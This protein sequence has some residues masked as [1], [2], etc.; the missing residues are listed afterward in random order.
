MA[1]D[2]SSI[3]TLT[4]SGGD[5]DPAWSPDGTKIA[6]A[7][8]GARALNHGD[9]FVVNSDGSGR[10]NLTNDPA[11]DDLPA[12][13]P[14]GTKIAFVSTRGGAHSIFVMNA[15]GT[16]VTRLTNNAGYDGEPAW[17]R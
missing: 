9:I 7:S 3:G 15:D 14:D 2:L 8:D 13:S 1:A 6:F 17:R 10:T 11:S 16:G 12:W 4:T 5:W